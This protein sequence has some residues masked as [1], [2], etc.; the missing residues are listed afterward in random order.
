MIAL[1]EL[2][3]A[4]GAGTLV[5][6]LVLYAPFAV[7]ALLAASVEKRASRT[8]AIV[9]FGLFLCIL[10]GLY[11]WGFRAS[12]IAMTQRKWTA[13]ALSLGFLVIASVPVLAVAG[14]VAWLAGKWKGRGSQAS[15]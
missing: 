15:A 7:I 3:P 12:E 9:F 4:T 2:M 14:V 8:V 11:F 10:G 5:G 1:D 13:A 6:N